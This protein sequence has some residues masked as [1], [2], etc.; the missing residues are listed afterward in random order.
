MPLLT[1][2]RLTELAV[3]VY[4]C[5]ARDCQRSI[6]GLL[7]ANPAAQLLDCGCRDGQFTLE[8]AHQIGAPQPTGIEIVPAVARLAR[9]RGVAAAVG[10]L[11]Q[12]LPFGDHTFD[13][14]VANQVIEHLSDT[15][16]FVR[17]LGR[18][19]RPGGY[20][21]LST[22]NLSS[23]HNLAALLLGK[24]P[25]PSDVSDDPSIGKLLP[26]F[27][28]DDCPGM[29]HLRVF[30]YDALRELLVRHGF[31]VEASLG[32]GYYPFLN[33]S[34]RLLSRLDKRHAAY[35]TIKVRP[36]IDRGRRAAIRDSRMHDN[37][38]RHA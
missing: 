19:L 30:A 25:F 38:A 13:V 18:V 3:N 9:A 12:P 29:T 37:G 10:D 27:E 28:G 22:N 21:V 15:D 16:G 36:A 32:V 5:S 20:A 23:W 31:H 4:E 11:N 17:E 35:Q 8:L 26:L 24:Q 2:S 33:G 14:L 34:A 6:L 1:R 7:E